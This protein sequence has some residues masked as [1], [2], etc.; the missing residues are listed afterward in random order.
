MCV[1]VRTDDIT[2]RRGSVRSYGAAAAAPLGYQSAVIVVGAETVCSQILARQ[3]QAVLISES[4]VEHICTFTF[5]CGARFRAPFPNVRRRHGNCKRQERS[6][7]C[8]YKRN[9]L[10]LSNVLGLLYFDT[11]CTHRHRHTDTQTLVVG[12]TDRHTQSHT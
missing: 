3:Q 2:Y 8:M 6:Q 7:T 9:A 11:K 5:A 1:C 10:V 4:G 12:C